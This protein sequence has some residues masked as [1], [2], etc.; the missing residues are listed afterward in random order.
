M[1]QNDDEKNSRVVPGTRRG[2]LG[3]F[4]RLAGGLAGGMLSEGARRLAGGE[5]PR[6]QELLLTPAN[7]GRVADRLS[8]LRGAAMKL[9]QMVSMD[10]GDILPPELSQIMARLREN[11]HAMPPKQLEAVL[12]QDWGQGWRRNFRYFNPRPLAAA[13]IGQV[14]RA[15]TRDGRDLAIKVQYPGVRESINADVD[16]VATLLRVSGL[17]PQQLDITPLLSAAKDQLREEADYQREAQQLSAYAKLLQGNDD[18]IVPG[19][20]EDLT[21]TNVLAMDFVPGRPIESLEEEPQDVRDAMMERLIDLVLR[22]LFEFRLMQT[23]PNFANYRVAEDGKRLVLLDF[24]AARPV[25]PA[26][27]DNYRRLF[28]AGLAEDQDAIAA[29]AIEAGFISH[30]AAT[31][32]ADSFNTIIRVILAELAKPGP[33]DFGDR[34]FVHTIREEG[35]A[36]AQDRATWHLPPAEILF[37]QRKISGTA[38]LAARLKARVDVRAMAE[39]KL[40]ATSSATST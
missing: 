29:A 19:L 5:R 20:H 24:G 39:A 28:L 15:T 27:S 1:S 31:A 8:H 17:L 7:I 12:A 38:L 21:T 26:I 40:A 25:S 33:F 11:A 30:H 3:Q 36:M 2:R 16:N 18:Y 32:H 10:A 23:D 9:G 4:G 35:M 34:A 37:V 14:H 22:E 6:M 13:S